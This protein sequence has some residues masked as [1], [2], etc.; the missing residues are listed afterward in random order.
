VKILSDMTTRERISG[1]MNHIAAPEDDHWL[2]ITW[3]LAGIVINLSIT[4][5]DIHGTRQEDSHFV[6]I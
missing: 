4:L 3:I 5:N 2:S 1:R 6:Q